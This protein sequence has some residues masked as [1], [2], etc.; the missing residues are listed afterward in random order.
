MVVNFVQAGAGTALFT[1]Y[2]GYPASPPALLQWIGAPNNP[3]WYACPEDGEQDYQLFKEPTFNPLGFR[4]NSC[5]PIL[6]AALDYSGPGL[7]D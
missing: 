7:S 1:P 6:L 2:N 5:F 3:S 4:N